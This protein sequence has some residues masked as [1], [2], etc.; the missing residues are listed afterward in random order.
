LSP[1][2][3][4]SGFA[5]I[6]VND[7]VIRLP[8]GSARS[9]ARLEAVLLQHTDVLAARRRVLAIAPCAEVFEVLESLSQLDR[10]YAVRAVS[11]EASL[12]SA[13]FDVVVADSRRGGAAEREGVREFARVLCPGGRLIVAV[14]TA[15]AAML[16]RRLGGEGFLVA[17]AAGDELTQVLVGVRGE[18]LPRPR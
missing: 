11:A 10:R 4:L 6:G 3:A 8:R 12:A 16:R 18:H 15:C 7:R 17:L 5:L 13:S 1:E 9:Q 2:S 14:P